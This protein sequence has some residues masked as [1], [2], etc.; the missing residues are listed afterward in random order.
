MKSKKKYVGWLN[1]SILATMIPV[2]TG[3]GVAIGYFLDKAF[4]TKPYMIIIFSIF[5]IIAGFKNIIAFIKKQEKIE[6]RA[7]K[8]LQNN[9]N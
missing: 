7:Q 8:D 4:N 2:S 9:S 3:V 1:L 5:G 6:N